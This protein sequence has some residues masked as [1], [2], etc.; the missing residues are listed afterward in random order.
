MFC[1]ALPSG[2]HQIVRR[3]VVPIEVVDEIARRNNCFFSRNLTL[4]LI[5][6]EAKWVHQVDSN[7]D[8]FPGTEVEEDIDDDTEEVRVAS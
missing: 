7:K 2:Y 3:D 4:A 5:R 6:D 8:L 1:F